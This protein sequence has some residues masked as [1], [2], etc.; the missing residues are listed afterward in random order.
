[1]NH[2]MDHMSH[3]DMDMAGMDMGDMHHGGT[4]SHMSGMGHMGNIKQRLIISTIM[5]IPVIIISPLMG[6]DIFHISFPGSNWLVL[7]L[8]TGLYFYGGYPFIGGAGEELKERKPAMMTL[9]TMGISVA[10]FYSLYAFAV[11]NFQ[12]H[13]GMHVMDFFW[14]LATLIVIMLLGH[15]IEMNSVMAAGN[16]VDKLS[17]LLPATAHLVGSDGQSSDVPT[18][19]IKVGDRVLIL[20][21]ESIP[22]DGKI[23]SGQ[24]FVNES[25]VTGESKSVEKKIND[26]VIGGSINNDGAITVE[27]TGA[28][29]SGY[30]SKVT[31]MVSE[32]QNSQSKAETLADK[33]AGWL[34]YSALAVGVLAFVIWLPISGA[35][36]AFSV[37]VTVFVI[38]CPHALGL[39][40]PLVVARSTSIAAVNGLLIRDRNATE[41]ATKIDMV[42]LDKTGTLT[43]GNFKVAELKSVNDAIT[44]KQ[45]TTI[46]ASLEKNSSHPIAKSITQYA[47]GLQIEVPTAENVE[48]IKGVGLSG[49][50]NNQDYLIVTKTYLDN[51]AISYDT[52]QYKDLANQG[53]SV[54]YLIQNKNVLGIVGT[55]DQIKPESKQFITRLKSMGITPVMLTGDNQATAEKVAH[56]IGIDEVQ[57]HLLPE[58]KQDVVKQYKAQGHRVMMVGDGVNDAPSLVSADIGV[59]IGAGTDVAIDAADVVLVNSNPQDIIHFLELSN[60]TKRKMV[61]N[62]WW[63]AGYNIIAMPLAAG[64][65]APIGFMLNPAVGALIMSFSTVIVA[66]NAMTLRIKRD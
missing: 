11:N 52:K 20:A 40:I 6:I 26:Q 16:A 63:G 44:D 64:I 45:A 35:S 17:A 12:S 36:E 37:M 48:T 58:N 30:L 1:M 65:L 32:A 24:T 56:E 38:A 10:Y 49:K 39:A 60:A 31:A 57:A 18:N 4:M 3:S 8:A 2:D 7:L 23:I 25:L 9:I 46:M 19:Q 27:V 34:F 33:V 42:L 54:S 62:L 51:Q 59:A 61:Q 50:V 43:N 47:E 29:D 15:W 53:L 55:G 66:L 28:G 14:E 5:A 22:A 13:G 41:T 21:G